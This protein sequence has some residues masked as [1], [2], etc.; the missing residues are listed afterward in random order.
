[1]RGQSRTR[2]QSLSKTPAKT[3]PSFLVLALLC[4]IRDK[5][6]MGNK[7]PEELPR[8]E[9]IVAI[10]RYVVSHPMAKDTISGIEKWWLS[11]SISREGKRKIEESLNLLVSK[12]WLI[13]RCSPQAETI[14]SLNENGLPE[15]NEFLRERT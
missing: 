14:Y 1:M 7:D 13:G 6:E 12:G 8:D 9:F 5:C 4:P 3:L 11:E 15:I 10:L 2:Q